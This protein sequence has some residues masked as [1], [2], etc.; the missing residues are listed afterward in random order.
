MPLILFRLLS[1]F[2]PSLKS[3]IGLLPSF[4]FFVK[5]PFVAI[6]HLTLPPLTFFIVLLRRAPMS[7]HRLTPYVGVSFFSIF[8]IV[9]LL[10]FSFRLYR[11]AERFRSMPWFFQT[12]LVHLGYSLFR[13]LPPNGKESSLFIPSFSLFFAVSLRPLRRSFG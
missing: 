1:Y 2:T 10:L 12:A 9:D 8:F 5:V 6:S 3:F 7:Q 11:L 13:L 4:L